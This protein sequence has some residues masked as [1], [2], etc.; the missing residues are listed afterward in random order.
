[1]SEIWENKLATLFHRFDKEKKGYLTKA[2]IKTQTDAFMA[3]GSLTNEEQREIEKIYDRLWN[4]LLN[5]KAQVSIDDWVNG[6][7]PLIESAEFATT[8]WDETLKKAG[9]LMFK[10]A[11]KR[12]KGA[13]TA[14]EFAGYL[15]CLGVDADQQAK[16]IFARFDVSGNGEMREDDFLR[17]FHDFNYNKEDTPGSELMGPLVC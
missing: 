10:V 6:H 7:R 8:I 16:D 17:A 4:T 15:Q 1:M 3:M 12:R 13:I 11:D 5:G 9:L 2:D 14:E